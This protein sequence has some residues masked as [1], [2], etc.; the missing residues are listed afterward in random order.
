[1]ANKVEAL[2]EFYRQNGWEEAASVLK[3]DTQRFREAGM[4]DEFP[5]QGTRSKKE[6]RTFTPLPIELKIRLIQILSGVQ[7]PDVARHILQSDGL[8]ERINQD[9]GQYVSDETQLGELL[10]KG[11]GIYEEFGNEF[12]HM[13]EYRIDTR[14]V[15]SFNKALFP[16]RANTAG[17][18]R[19]ARLGELMKV[20][21]AGEERI[22]F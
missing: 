1:M 18:I 21:Q 12:K 13:G 4:P 9:V 16:F 2:A 10:V 19:T 11:K 6:K 20:T 14:L 5:D 3:A 17:L 8:V 22:R 15:L 7:L